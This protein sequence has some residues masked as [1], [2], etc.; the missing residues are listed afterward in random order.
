MMKKFVLIV[1]GSFVGVWIA[2]TLFTIFSVV[3][4]FLMFGA[5]AS[6]GEKS[7]SVGKNAILYLP[8]SGEIVEREGTQA[9]SFN[10]Y[11]QGTRR[12]PSLETI[13][14]ALN[15][16]TTDKNIKGVYVDC[17]GVSAAPA[18]LYTIRKALAKYKK[19]SKG[20]FVYAY[21]NEG[22]SQGDYYIAT[23]CDSIFLNPV[24]MVDV[25]G[26]GSVTPFFKGLLDKLGIEMQILRVGTFKSAV[27]P[28]MLDS[29]SPAN[30]EQQEHYLGSIWKNFSTQMAEGRG[31][32]VDTFNQ[33]VDSVMATVPAEELK[34]RV[35][36]DELCYRSD[37]EKKLKKLTNTDMT[38]DLNLVGPEEVA[39]TNAVSSAFGSMGGPSGKH[40]AVVYA[41][42]EIDGAVSYGGGEGIDSQQLV[43]VIN[44]LEQNDDVQGIVLRVNS[45]GGSAFGSEQIWKALD[46]FKK[47]TNKPFAVSMGDYA[48]S[49]GYYISCGAD[50]IFAE[51]VTITGSIGIFGMIPNAQG[52][53]ENKLGIHTSVVKTNANADMG[54]LTQPLTAQ[55]RTALQAYVNRGY[56]LFTERCAN[57]RHVS[58]DSIKAI[59]EGRVWD[60]TTAKQIGLVDEFGSLGDAVKWVAEKA[61]IKDGKIKTFSYPTVEDQFM[62]MFGQY[63]ALREQ[64]KMR[65]R[66]GLFYDYYIEAQRIMQR[67]HVL[68]LMETPFIN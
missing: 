9:I 62:R 10:D 17:N 57:G 58:Q 39:K 3:M 34:K 18:T 37:F 54:T 26:F 16:A 50:R 6:M 63:A 55:Q 13:V 44:D 52:L 20:K 65:E 56:E 19:E 45:P 4:S 5:M 8:L 27:E 38:D 33:Y 42:G 22:I 46:D 11:V 67:K 15:K 48:A 12:T 1:C 53:M 40:I 23:A 24:G 7:K 35:I 41:V 60:A 31:I 68:C 14:A 25:H 43:D 47:N 51:P 61:A 32:L 2:L 28:Y 36:I 59:A 29:I 21:G 30:R 49:G 66:M 64:E